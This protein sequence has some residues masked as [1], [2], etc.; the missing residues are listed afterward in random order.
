MLHVRSAEPDTVRLALDQCAEV[1]FELAILT[2]GSG[3]DVEDRSDANLQRWRELADY[4]HRQG[5]QLGGYSLRRAAVSSPT[6]TTA[7][8]WTLAGPVASGSARAGAGLALGAGLLRAAPA[9]DA[10][11]RP[12]LHEARRRAHAVEKKQ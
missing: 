5:V 1:G 7:S 12:P 3:F 4:A 6:A 8:A 10:A 2:S 11:A 9:V